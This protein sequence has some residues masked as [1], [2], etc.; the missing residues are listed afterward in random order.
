MRE[1]ASRLGVSIVEAT[2]GDVESLAPGFAGTCDAVLVDAPCSNVGVLRRNP[3]VKWRRDT[4]DLA[5]NARRQRT[6]LEA[7]ATMLKPG[8]RLVYATCSTE[9]E[10]NDAVAR[11]LLDARD[12]LTL[13]PPSCFPI[14]LGADG[15]F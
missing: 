3:E 15:F 9:P 6:I 1:S 14:T 5:A 7:A 10:E 12:D 11:W 4:A 8:G 13:D 2:A